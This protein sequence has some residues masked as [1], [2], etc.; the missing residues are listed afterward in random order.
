VPLSTGHL[1]DQPQLDGYSKGGENLRAR[2]AS[3]NPPITP[4]ETLAV[5]QSPVSGTLRLHL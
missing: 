1:P 2:R 3:F 4:I 5:L